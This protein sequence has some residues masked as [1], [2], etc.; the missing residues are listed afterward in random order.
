[1]GNK[2]NFIRIGPQYITDV[3][4][5]IFNN[6]SLPQSNY[7]IR[8]ISFCNTGEAAS[9]FSLFLG[10]TDPASDPP[11]SYPTNDLALYFNKG[12]QA[13]ETIHVYYSP[14]LRMAAQNFLMV[15]AADTNI[16]TVTG[17]IEGN[18]TDIWI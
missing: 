11:T 13:G 2:L 18:L 9:S 1:M 17:L 5:T 15:S 16:I 10:N 12:I 8:Q 3:P 6:S 4:T 7:T 14:G